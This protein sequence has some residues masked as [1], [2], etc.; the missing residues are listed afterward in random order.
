MV[1]LRIILWLT[2][3]SEDVISR[4]YNLNLYNL[5]QGKSILCSFVED[6][7]TEK[8]QGYVI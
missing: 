7:Y 4:K 3:A 2:T 5:T 1:K 6:I 8:D